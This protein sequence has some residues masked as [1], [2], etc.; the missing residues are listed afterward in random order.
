MLIDP[1]KLVSGQLWL[2]LR[3]AVPEQPPRYCCDLVP[4]N[5]CLQLWVMGRAADETP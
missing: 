2:P 1:G 3:S 5:G 4:D